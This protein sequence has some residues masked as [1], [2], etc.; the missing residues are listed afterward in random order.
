MCVCCEVGN[1]LCFLFFHLFRLCWDVFPHCKQYTTAP[2][3]RWTPTAPPSPQSPVPCALVWKQQLKLYPRCSSESNKR[4]S[5]PSDGTLFAEPSCCLSRQKLHYGCDSRLT[6]KSAESLPSLS[7]QCFPQD[8]EISNL[9]EKQ[10][11]KS[12]FFSEI[13][14]K[15]YPGAEK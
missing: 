2:A 15:A 7:I 5:G 9:R 11:N 14:A 8:F 6:N 13:L 3:W 12:I 1:W 4:A 10:P